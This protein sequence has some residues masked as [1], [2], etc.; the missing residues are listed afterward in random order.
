MSCILRPA[1]PSLR[2]LAKEPNVIDFASRRQIGEGALYLD[3]PDEDEFHI[4]TYLEMKLGCN[5][6]AREA[7]PLSPRF[8]A[9]VRAHRFR[10]PPPSRKRWAAAALNFVALLALFAG[11]YSVLTLTFFL[12]GY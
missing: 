7:A 3:N 12:S 8:R 11:L 6:S 4:R 10:F 1:P 5:Q 9:G 2:P